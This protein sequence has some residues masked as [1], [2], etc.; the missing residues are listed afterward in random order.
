MSRIY[1]IAS[2][3]DWRDARST[4]SYEAATLRAEGFIHCST[5][6]QVVP[7]ADAFFRGVAGL[8]LMEIDPEKLDAELR[9][10]ENVGPDGEIGRFPHVYG[11]ISVAAVVAV[12]ALAPQAD[13][14][15]TFP[16]VE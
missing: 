14:S 10:E 16:G 8:V 9:F 15:F 13:G 2:A 4:S 3:A 6:E 12:H 7:V 5:R 11:P 1:H